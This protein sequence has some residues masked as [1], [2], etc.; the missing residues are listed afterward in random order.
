MPESSDN[1][2]FIRLE[3]VT[4]NYG[5]LRAL[6][7]VSFVIGKGE[8]FGYVGPN[9]AGKTTTIKILVGLVSDFQ[10]NVG[11]GEYS[12]PGNRTHVHKILGYLPQ[13]VGFQSWRT[14][15]HALQTFGKLSGLEPDIIDKRIESL[16]ELFGLPEV[17]YR[18]INRLSGGTIQK[19]GLVQ[20]LLHEPEFLVLDEPLA[21]LDPESR[22]RVKEVLRDLCRNGVTLFFSS[23]I[24]SDVQDI[25]TKIGIV[26]NGAIVTIGTLSELKSEF[27]SATTIEIVLS[28][29][30]DR[31]SSL[32]S[33]PGV[34]KVERSESEKITVRLDG[35]ADTD[36]TIHTIIQSLLDS[37]CQIRSIAPAELS[38]DDVYLKYIEGDNRS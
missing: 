8:V 28:G 30:S 27:A 7:N 23:H 25:A 20:A 6:N 3:N 11:I 16:L 12:M 19:V 9:G 35:D 1:N 14:V 36:K 10:G 2:S 17:R 4:K 29:D 15:E 26:N 37:G 33:L 31:W 34:D 21:G 5:T 18:K 32:K 38:L 13:K 24:L 22:F